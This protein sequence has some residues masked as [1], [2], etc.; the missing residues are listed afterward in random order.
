MNL[1]M[2]VNRLARRLDVRPRMCPDCGGPTPGF[3]LYFGL[4]RKNKPRWGECD[5]CGLAVDR[6][7][8]AIAALPIPAGE[9]LPQSKVYG[10]GTPL[11]RV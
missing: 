10:P 11:E 4:N 2:R 3:N 6:R 7:G 9:A 8:K 5:T 1:A